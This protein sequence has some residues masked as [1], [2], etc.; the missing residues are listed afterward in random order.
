MISPRSVPRTPAGS[1]ASSSSVASATALMRLPAIALAPPP[2]ANLMAFLKSVRHCWLIALPCALAVA[3]LTGLIG[4]LLVPQATLKYQATAILTTDLKPP[5]VLKAESWNTND[6]PSYRRTQIDLLKSRAILAP[7]VKRP[8]VVEFVNE[9]HLDPEQVI[10]CLA[11]NLKIDFGVQDW[12]SQ[13]LRITL[14]GEDADQTVLLVNAIQHTFVEKTV[15]DARKL[16]VDRLASLSRS[17]ETARRDLESKRKDFLTAAG[18]SGPV[19]LEEE[20]IATM[21]LTEYQRQL[22]H[23]EVARVRTQ[24]RAKVHVA[25]KPPT[26]SP[27]MLA[28]WVE[29]DGQV[30]DLRK[31]LDAIREDMQ[32]IRAIAVQPEA[33]E[34]YRE[35]MSMLRLTQESL[36]RRRN[37]MRPK[38]EQRLLQIARDSVLDDEE[39]NGPDERGLAREANLLSQRVALQSQKVRE[40]SEQ[41]RKFELV[42][43][44]RLQS[45]KA[46]VDALDNSARAIKE[47]VDALEME[48]LAPPRVHSVGD[49]AAEPL[50]ENESFNRLRIAGF[51]SL[52]LGALTM[53]GFGWWEFQR[54][55]I[56]SADDVAGRLG[57]RVIGSLPSHTGWQLPW[58]KRNPDFLKFAKQTAQDSVDSAATLVAHEMESTGARVVLVTSALEHEGKTTLASELAASFARSGHKTLLIDSDLIRPTLHQRFGF[59]LVPGLSEALWRQTA[60]DAGI[61]ALPTPNL[62]LLSA[63][64]TDSRV[65]QALGRDAMEPLLTHYREE[66]DTIVIDSSPVLPLAHAM[67]ISKHVDAA[68]LAVRNNQSSIPAV[69]AAYQRLLALHVQVMGAVFIGPGVGQVAPY[70][71]RKQRLLRA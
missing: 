16:A 71:S 54:Q 44:E 28:A 23:L 67:R 15:A 24:A 3:L 35:L 52:M 68:I 51:A 60:P 33:L 53:I 9:R 13:V 31:R 27:E 34:E 70:R 62:F 37:E 17:Y 12:P 20:Q 42:Q 47:K 55:H 11:N 49:V 36:D 2:R 8:E 69:S 19:S 26:V 10:R 4:W 38:I 6:Y 58:T 7:A 30:N 46:E 65:T 29:K 57:L 61:R 45:A 56:H 64:Q 18:E 41:R 50:N 22:S 39:D 14:Q 40:L 48:R 63:G 5:V 21:Q 25:M 66:F 43:S 59:P 32:K 1:A